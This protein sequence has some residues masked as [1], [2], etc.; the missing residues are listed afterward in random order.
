MVEQAADKGSLVKDR[1]FRLYLVGSIVSGLGDAMFLL[2]LNW[3]VVK[4]TGSSTL[5]GLLLASMSVPQIV[6]TMLSGALVDRLNPRLLMIV[7]DGL[8]LLVMIFLL[9]VSFG[10]MP[11]LWSL[12]AMAIVFGTVDSVY[13][14][15]SSSFQQRLVVPEKYTQASG[16]VMS[17]TQGS[18]IVGPALA[19]LLIA[20][21]S[22]D[23]IITI[24]A[25]TYLVSAICISLVRSSGHER[26][27]QE[28][29]G[30]ILSDVLEGVRYVFRTPLVLITSLSAFVVNASV[31]ALLVAMPIMARSFRLGAQGFGLMTTGLAI[32]GAAGSLFFVLVV[33]KRPTPRMTF[34]ANFGEGAMLVGMSL[35]HSL[36][37]LL[38][39]LVLVGMAEAVVNTVAP[40]VNRAVIPQQL[41][42]RVISFM[43]V[44]MSGSE[45]LAKAAAGLAMGFAGV[46]TVL[47]ISGLLEMSIVSV[48]FFLGPIK[49]YSRG[50]ASGP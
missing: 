11:P 6:L 15:A 40:S 26:S 1:N 14:P 31:A 29:Q 21:G 47:I 42:G 36:L 18:Q 13:W 27:T 35:Y 41:F 48:G 22:F 34:V 50:V 45:P 7:S 32:G 44:L 5:L 25:A 38:A 43:I 37:P 23:L 30:S 10:G 49:R 9:L 4:T 19:G 3:I 39:M 12:F 46:R 33:V 28:S 16:I 17:M 20:R 8:R 24:N 2:A